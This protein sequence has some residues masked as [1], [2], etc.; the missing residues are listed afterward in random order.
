MPH[1]HGCLQNM[2]D[3]HSEA[4]QCAATSTVLMFDNTT[5]C[6]LVFLLHSWPVLL[7]V[8]SLCYCSC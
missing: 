2:V 3:K 4:V 1:R 8:A 5:Q 6:L 7:D